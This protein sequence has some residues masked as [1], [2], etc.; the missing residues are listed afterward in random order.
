[1][2]IKE[3]SL[4]RKFLDWFK[5]KTGYGFWEPSY[6]VPSIG[7]AIIILL[8]IL[9]AWYFDPVWRP[10]LHYYFPDSIPLLGRDPY[11]P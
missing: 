8:L 5:S 2:I 10:F 1:M 6:D 11:T 4:Y 9:L 7:T 3:R